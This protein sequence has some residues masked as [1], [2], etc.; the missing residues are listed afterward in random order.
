M[1]KINMIYLMSKRLDKQNYLFRDL[2]L[3]TTAVHCMIS[4]CH[5]SQRLRV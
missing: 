5:S 3:E 1:I 2:L 4:K